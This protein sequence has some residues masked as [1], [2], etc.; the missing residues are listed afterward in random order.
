MRSNTHCKVQS[1]IFDA[2]VLS[3]PHNPLGRCYSQDVLE[4][5]IKFCEKHDIHLVSDEV[6]AL[7]EF[8]APDLEDAPRFTSILSI[9]AEALCADPKRVH[10]IWSVKTSRRAGLDS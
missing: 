4:R 9:D 5:C 10:T 6:F 1:R 2:L 7:S 8:D 3:N